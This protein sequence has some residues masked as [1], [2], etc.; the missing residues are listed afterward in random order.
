LRPVYLLPFERAPG[1]PTQ[2]YRQRLVGHTLHWSILILNLTG[3]VM[4]GVVGEQAFGLGD[5]THPSNFIAIN[6]SP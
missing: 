4:I 3:E 6:L 2:K 5:G 1:E